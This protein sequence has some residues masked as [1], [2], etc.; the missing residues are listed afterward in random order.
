M[1]NDTN[2][3]RPNCELFQ[4]FS[5]T[6]D[7]IR[8]EISTVF[9]NYFEVLS[10]RF[11]RKFQQ[12]F[13]N[14]WGT[15]VCNDIKTVWL[16]FEKHSQNWPRK[17]QLCNFS[18]FFNNCLTIGTKISTTILH[19]LGDLRVQWDQHCKAGIQATAEIDQGTA[20]CQVFQFCQK[21]ST[22]FERNFLQSF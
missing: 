6:V 21:Q 12:L 11:E 5:K 13:H 20:I 19:F 10:I 16:G 22:R 2:I 4:F 7:A 1:C 18:I 8:T 9:L 3:V 15:F 17:T 14:M